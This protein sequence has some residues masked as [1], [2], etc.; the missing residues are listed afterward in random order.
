[1]GDLP[2]VKGTIELDGGPGTNAPF[3]HFGDGMVVVSWRGWGH[4][5]PIVEPGMQWV[6]SRTSVNIWHTAEVWLECQN[7]QGF[8]NIVAFDGSQFPSHRLWVNG[9]EQRFRD[10][11]TFGDLWDPK[12]GELSFVE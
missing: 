9:D 8:Y 4:P 11:N 12:A 5:N 10:Q 1:M 3:L 2:L 7:G 6:A